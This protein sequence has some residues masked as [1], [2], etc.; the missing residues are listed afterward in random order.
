MLVLRLQMLRQ[1]VSDLMTSADM[2]AIFSEFCA[3][4]LSLRRSLFLELIGHRGRERVV[5]R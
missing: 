5:M 2:L 1:K 3:L 4:D